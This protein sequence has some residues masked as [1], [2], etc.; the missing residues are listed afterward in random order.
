MVLLQVTVLPGELFQVLHDLLLIRSV[1]K[2]SVIPGGY[3]V[4]AVG[5]HLFMQEGELQGWIGKYEDDCP[6]I[7]TEPYGTLASSFIGE[8]PATCPVCRKKKKLPSRKHAQGIFESSQSNI[9]Q[10]PFSKHP[11]S[12]TIKG[13]SRE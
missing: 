5:S 10:R 8:L 12:Q 6:L 9:I 13:V 7:I 2:S 3:Q 11:L 1:L 4:L